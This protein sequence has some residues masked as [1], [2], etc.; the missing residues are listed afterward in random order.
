MKLNH[1]EKGMLITLAFVT[2]EERLGKR[3]RAVPLVKEHPLGSLKCGVFVSVYTGK[4]LRGCIGTFSEEELLVKNIREMSVSA[5]LY[6]NRFEPVHREDLDEMTIELSVLSPRQRM[7]DPSQIEL[8]KHG[9]FIEKGSFR[10][11]LLP[12]V[13]LKQ[14]WDLEQFLGNCSEYKAGIGWDGWKTAD[15]FTYE[16]TV[17]N[18][19]TY[20][21]FT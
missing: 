8:G 16:A 6:D 4:M 10:G 13:P 9:I 17:F 2:I 12:Q 1:T 21:P 14:G 19:V 20:P 11:T 7:D 5:A 15:V 18:S 3:A